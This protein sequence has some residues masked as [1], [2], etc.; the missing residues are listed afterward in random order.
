MKETFPTTRSLSQI[1]SPRTFYNLFKGRKI[2]YLYSVFACM[3]EYMYV[4]NIVCVLRI[5]AFG[6]FFV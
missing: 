3:Y 4:R 2:C 6:F 1:A 5:F